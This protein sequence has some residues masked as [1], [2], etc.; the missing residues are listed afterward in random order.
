MK[1]NGFEWRGDRGGTKST[2]H[3][4]TTV[5]AMLGRY[6]IRWGIESDILT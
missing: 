3:F 4:E 6:L 5:E 1:V 2:S